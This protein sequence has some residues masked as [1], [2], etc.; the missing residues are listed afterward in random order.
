[1]A[2]NDVRAVLAAVGDG[3]DG[4]E[5]L[6]SVVGV[7][8]VADIV[9]REVEDRVYA[10]GALRHSGQNLMLK[11]L[12]VS[13]AGT[14]D[15]YITNAPQGA[16]ARHIATI[17]QHLTELACAVFG[18][19]GHRT[20]CIRWHDDTPTASSYEVPQCAG[21]VYRVLECMTTTKPSLAEL[22]L[23]HR[24]DKW[25]LHYYTDAYDRYL[26][27]RRTEHL[28]VLELGVGG[29]S[30]ASSGGGSLA[31][32]HSYFPR[33]EIYG[34]DIE[35]KD[36]SL[37]FG[38]RV[39][40]FQGSQSD[41]VALNRVLADS[42]TLDLVIDD[43]SHRA[44]DILASFG[45]LFPKVRP[46]GMYVIEDLQ[47]SYWP[48]FGGGYPPPRDVV[49]AIELLKSLVDALHHEEA[50]LAGDLAM[51]GRTIG[52]IHVHHNIAFIEAA[53][54]MEGSLPKWH[55]ARQ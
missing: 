10:T 31:M 12:L 23:S 44:S 27:P 40:I 9:M 5:A 53:V 13:R 6:V 2:A 18:R 42:G 16:P 19:G 45:F 33:A 24:S 11:C 47:T 15:R 28:K 46:G 51:L 38:Q 21:I 49:T 32:W 25:G 1:M 54:N 29:F 35:R 7:D 34:L 8:C 26:C 17:S 20:R 48:K 37:R 41:E 30:E 50:D 3:M 43:G 22:A 55:P 14:V 4:V 39:K 52:G 36:D